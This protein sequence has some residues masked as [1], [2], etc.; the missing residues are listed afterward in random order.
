MG[1]LVRDILDSAQ[2]SVLEV[3]EYSGVP[4]SNI[5]RYLK[6]DAEPTLSVLQEIALAAGVDLGVVVRTLSDGDASEAVKIILGVSSEVTSDGVQEWVE[7]ITRRKPASG[8]D[9]LD[10]GGQA[11][12]VLHRAGAHYF[13]GNLSVLTIAS[14]GD[15]TDKQWAL[16]GAPALEALGLE[17]TDAPTI[18]WAVDAEG[19]ARALKKSATPLPQP[20]GAN[21]V[22]VHA[23]HKEL[24]EVTVREGIRLVSVLQGLIDVISLHSTTKQQVRQYLEKSEPF[25]ASSRWEGDITTYKTTPKSFEPE[26]YSR[27]PSVSSA[28]NQI[29]L[30]GVYWDAT[31]ID[32]QK[33]RQGGTDRARSRMRARLP[34]LIWSTAALEGNT[35]TLPEVQTLLDGVTVEGKKLEE[36]Q[37][38]LALQ[39]TFNFLD[40]LVSSESFAVNQETSHQFHGRVARHEAIE[41]GHFRGQGDVTGGGAVRL[42]TGERVE[43][44][45][46]DQI[47]QRFA[48]IVDLVTSEKDPRL[49]ALMYFA[50]A[51]RSQLYF[52]GNKRTARMMASGILM[53]HGYDAIYIPLE[54]R[55]EYNRC[56][57]VLFTTNNATPLMMFIASCY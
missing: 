30:T 10:I 57:D 40:V 23:I 26:G 47:E 43:G 19:A 55:L 1:N 11:S 51:I 28:E 8:W 49:A 15:F 31:S 12:N 21:I 45:S 53:S 25:M 46:T 7:R 16:S 2:L 14:A 38:V 44:L 22:V 9:V 13:R 20:D 37:Q 5:Y 48:G 35:F 56:L 24:E 6:G 36:E 17:R 4:K 27:K 29:A 50:S 18:L 41:A 52:D 34:E 32:L 33:M 3:A 42:S 39:D 54:R